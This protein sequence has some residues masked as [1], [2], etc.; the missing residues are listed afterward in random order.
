MGIDIYSAKFLQSEKLR[1][2]CWERTLTLGHQELYMDDDDYRSLAE[3][4]GILDG[5][6][7]YADDLFRGLGAATLDVMDVSDFE[8]ANILHDLNQPLDTRLYGAY[9]CV[10][11]GGALEHVFNFPVALKNC[12]EMV[13]VGGCFITITPMNNWCGHGFYQFSPE[14]FYNAL[15]SSNGFS[16]E[17]L[18]FIHRGKWYSVRKPT[19]VRERIEL[20]TCEST[21]LFV[22]ARRHEQKSIFAKWPQQSDYARAWNMGKHAANSDGSKKSIKEVLVSHS[23]LLKK[24]QTSWRNYKQ[25]KRY[26]PSNRAWFTPVDMG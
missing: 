3:S 1:G 19:D 23:R 16:V 12:M 18:L 20:L 2:V 14:L 24:L 8:G 9:D 4:I 25:R 22:T 17:Q 15:S 6:T 26:S 5:N 13:K 7:K 21:Q 10:F 11:D